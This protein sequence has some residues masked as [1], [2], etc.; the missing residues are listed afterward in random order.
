MTTRNV[1]LF[2]WILTVIVCALAL[3]AWKESFGGVYATLTSYRLFPL[4]GLLA[5]SLMWTHYIVGAVRRACKVERAP[6]ASYLE[7][8]GWA[9]LVFIL[10]HPSVLILQLWRDGLGLPPNSYLNYVGPSLKWA[11][12]LG[13]FGFLFFLAF[14]TKRW[15][16]K[17]GWW[18]IIE[19]G[20]VV[21]MFA[22]IIH[23]LALGS[24]LQ[25]GWYRTVWLV[26]AATLFIS[27]CYQYYLAAQ[28][29]KTEGKFMKK[30]V[31]IV[32]VLV[33]VLGLG[34]FGY[35]QLRSDTKQD[36]ATVVTTSTDQQQLDIEKQDQQVYAVAEVA[37]HNSVTDCWTII[38]GSVYDITDYVARHP[39]GDVIAE[40]CGTDGTTMF[41]KRQD[42]RG[43]S[44][45]SGEAHSTS[46][47]SQ[48][49]QFKIGT[50]AQ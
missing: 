41:T 50:V 46:A 34:A 11:V 25:A 32:I 28:A 43:N 6:L 3:L 47:E 2:A 5:F 45:G 4:F 29:A 33:L 22:I 18:P 37:D 15:F 16:S 20:N 9:A 21:A 42:S 8:T 38:S 30:V 44:I 17:K 7:V 26:Y 19:Y 35:S 49:A 23:A 10:L 48:L 14:E 31:G 12:A 27:I 39:G 1:R 24:D 36:D 13:T 40:A